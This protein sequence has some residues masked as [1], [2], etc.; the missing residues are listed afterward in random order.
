MNQGDRVRGILAHSV[1]LFAPVTLEVP[2]NRRG[3]SLPLHYVGCVER[4]EAK[5][6][7]SW[8][9]LTNEA[10]TNES[11]ALTITGYYEHRWLER[12]KKNR[13]ASV[14]VIWQ[15]WFKLQIILEGYDLAMSLDIDL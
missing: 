8:H 4:S 9:L 2:H 5:E 11:K 15:G 10:V 3:D 6:S 14:K 13:R 7:L 1:L 12:Y